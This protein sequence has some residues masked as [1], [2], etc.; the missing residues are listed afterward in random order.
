MLVPV[1]RTFSPGQVVT[2]AFMNEF[3]DALNFLLQGFPLFIAK[4]SVAQSLPDGAWTAI[5]FSTE[6]LDRDS[7][8]STSVNT[9]RY[10][11]KTPGWYRVVG[12]AGTGQF[13]GQLAAAIAKNGVRVPSA[14]STGPGT[15]PGAGG[16]GA[17]AWVS[18]NGTGDWV[19]LQIYQATGGVVNTIVAGDFCSSLVVEWKSN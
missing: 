2:A 3:R 16:V 1:P 7:G 13:S 14:G 11:P 10:V 6:T 18:L 5:T 17:E 9:M 19:E 8:H 4:Q 12:Y 15:T